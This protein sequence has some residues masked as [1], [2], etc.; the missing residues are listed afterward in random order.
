MDEQ[1]KKSLLTVLTLLLVI[2]GACPSMA[3]A[4]ESS[5]SG[6]LSIVL[7]NDAFH[8]TDRHYTNGLML[9]WVPGPEAPTPEWAMMM[10]RLMPWFAGRG[11]IRHGYA[12]GQSMFTSG[13]IDVG[14][15]PLGDRPYAG[16]LYGTIGIGEESGR[17]LDQLWMT[18]GMVGPASLAEQTQK[19]LHKVLPG[20]E[21]RG[22]DTQLGNEPGIVV[23]CQRS[24][25]GVATSSL[26][27]AGLDF[28]PHIGGALGNV[29]T[30]GNAGLT[31]RF[32]NRLPDDY[33]PPRIQPG[34]PGS[35]DF[36]PVSGFGWYLF[37]G[38]E[39]RGVA[40]NIFL[41][42]NTFRDSRSVDKKYLVG[43]LQFGFVLDWS[44]M[45]LGYTHVLRSREFRTQENKDYFGALSVS[46]KF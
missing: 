14:N 33:G 42:G 6:T 15:P 32:G 19:F 23:T 45:R 22:W 30:Y 24:W 29:F 9:V 25:R 44:D 3:W 43:D 13:D 17:R 11:E 41:D 34:L 26:F 21:P 2:G 38:I 7:E 5:K 37:A 16:W 36:S 40:R 18:F 8:G 35:W 31:M 39:G 4:G 27:G 46:F 12:F 1:R 10:A 28:A 20:G